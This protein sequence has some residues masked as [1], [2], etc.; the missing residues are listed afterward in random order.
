MGRRMACLASAWV[1]GGQ[2]SDA[3]AEA[4]AI[5]KAVVESAGVV[6]REATAPA[7]DIYIETCKTID[8][9]GETE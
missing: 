5:Y 4:L 6:F 8:G 2:M 3:K 1:S 9:E 7:W